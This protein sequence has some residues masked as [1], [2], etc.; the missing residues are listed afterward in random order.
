MKLLIDT[1]VLIWAGTAPTRLSSAATVLLS[2]PANTL[3]FSAI[4]VAEIAIKR[5][6]GRPDFQI[7][8]RRFRELLLDNGYGEL[9]LSGEHAVVLAALPTIHNDPFDRMLIAQATAEG[10]RLV[11]G[12]RNVVRYGGVVMSV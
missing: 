6:L 2:D 8:P 1:R 5:A 10:V 11:S 9:P 7:D 3:L 4:S 12:D